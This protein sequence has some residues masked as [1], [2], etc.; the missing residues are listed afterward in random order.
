M[1]FQHDFVTRC[2]PLEVPIE[3]QVNVIVLKNE[4]MMLHSQFF[5]GPIM[6]ILNMNRFTPNG[7][8]QKTVGCC[9]VIRLTEKKHNT[10]TNIDTVRA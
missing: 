4:I 1:G 9:L 8:M 6:Q 5:T 7:A 2:I 10:S 3:Y